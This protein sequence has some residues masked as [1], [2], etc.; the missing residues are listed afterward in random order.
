MP[1]FPPSIRTRQQ[2][3]TIYWRNSFAFRQQ[4]GSSDAKTIMTCQ[5]NHVSNRIC[6]PEVKGSI[7]L[8]STTVSGPVLTNGPFTCRCGRTWRHWGRAG[9]RSPPEGGSLRSVAAPALARFA[10]VALPWATWSS[11]A[12]DRAGP[13]SFVLLFIAEC[14]RD[15]LRDIC[16]MLQKRVSPDCF[17]NFEHEIEVVSA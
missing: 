13:A 8:C 4:T 9:L 10:L 5:V 16:D 7:P 15:I 11:I 12:K 3:V 2:K 17:L 1:S 14:A 6:K